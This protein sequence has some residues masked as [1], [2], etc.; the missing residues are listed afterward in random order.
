MT[1]WFL[2][3]MLRDLERFFKIID[4]ENPPEKLRN[5][6]LE[7]V[8]VQFEKHFWTGKDNAAV[9]LLWDKAKAMYRIYHYLMDGQ[10][11]CPTRKNIFS[12]DL[13]ILSDEEYQDVREYVWTLITD[14]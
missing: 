7:H 6:F 8:N 14:P 2:F 5:I 1:L 10:P 11:N 9:L 13:K 4:P 12:E 3:F